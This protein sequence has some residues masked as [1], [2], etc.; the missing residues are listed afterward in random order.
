MPSANRHLRDVI[1]CAG[2]GFERSSK[3][4]PSRLRVF[5]GERAINEQAKRAGWGATRDRALW[6]CP[7]HLHFGRAL[8]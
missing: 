7:K 5:G 1:A 6:L 8:G 4:C 3:L 2:S